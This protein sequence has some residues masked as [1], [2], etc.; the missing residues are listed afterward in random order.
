VFRL[1]LSWADAML[2][3]EYD[4]EEHRSIGR[5]GDDLDRDAALLDL[6]WL[7]LRVTDK[8]LREPDALAAR[9]LRHLAQ[10]SPRD[11]RQY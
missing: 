10:R 5:H 2:A 11:A 6:G 8:Q 7:V 1:D 4:G 3:V 9:V